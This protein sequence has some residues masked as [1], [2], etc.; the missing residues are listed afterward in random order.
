MLAVVRSADS[1]T[2]VVGKQFSLA[3]GRAINESPRYE[4]VDLDVL[5]G[6][7]DMQRAQREL[8]AARRKARR[9]RDALYRLEVR[10]S[11][12]M[13]REAITTYKEN[14]AFLTDVSELSSSLMHL[15]ANEVRK[16]VLATRGSLTIT[17]SPPSALAVVDGQA[18]GLTPITI[19]D[20]HEGR[21]VVRVIDDGLVSWGAV[22]D[23][24][25][26]AETQANAILKTPIKLPDL[27]GQIGD[28]YRAAARGGNAAAHVADLG[29]PLEVEQVLL[30]RIRR[31]RGATVVDAAL[32]GVTHSVR[33]TRV[34]REI[35]TKGD[36]TEYAQD[37]LAKLT[38]PPLAILVA[39]LHVPGGRADLGRNAKRAVTELIG[40]LGG[41]VSFLSTPLT[42]PCFNDP[43]CV[44]TAASSLNADGVLEIEM[45]GAGR[46]RVRTRCLDGH[47]GANLWTDQFT[48]VAESLRQSATLR[49]AMSRTI[50]AVWETQAKDE[51][52]EPTEMDTV[53][54]D[55]KPP[56]EAD[57]LDAPAPE[58][59]EPTRWS[60][61]LGWT[62]VGLGTATTIGATV[63]AF[64]RNAVL[65][66]PASSGSDKSD[67]R[68]TGMFALGAAAVG[69]GIVA[70]GSWLTWDSYQ[71]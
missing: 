56:E 32:Y 61:V 31:V 44:H 5:A 69:A 3:L 26:N 57:V 25:A 10:E 24:A 43:A 29:R 62:T 46:L 14:A 58:N 36:M 6:G 2:A 16:K 68:R 64:E 20:L 53:I 11:A 7:P 49:A 41:T 63:L 42:P 55:P 33:L 45:K 19:H 60:R 1:E 51:P 23:V 59:A 9:G 15:G 40:G 35:T 65:D 34:K 27:P 38:P 71:D 4:W 12:Q 66:D 8:D 21:H 13:L 17:S 30:V 48:V 54:W 39:A 22:I 47:T 28:A 18:V 67:A 70:L 37:L 52:T 50:D